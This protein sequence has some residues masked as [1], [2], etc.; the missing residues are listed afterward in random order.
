MA[1]PD[2]DLVA[3]IAELT[4]STEAGAALVTAATIDRYLMML[5][6]CAMRAL[7]PGIAQRI[8]ENYGPLYELGPKADIAFAFKLIDE[9]TLGSIRAIKEIRNEFAHAGEL[10]HF[11]SPTILAKCQALP[12]FK[13]DVNAR[14]LFDKIAVECIRSNRRQ[15]WRIHIRRGFESRAIAR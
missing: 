15:N 14:E 5:L 3:H 11:N 12:G 10:V 8:F 4:R 13:K 6:L 9:R 1:E 7:S 2:I